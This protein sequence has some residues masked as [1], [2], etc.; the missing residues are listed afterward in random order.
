MGAIGDLQVV[1]DHHVSFLEAVDFLQKLLRV[2]DDTVADHAVLLGREYSGWNQMQCIFL[3]GD[4]DGMAGI[5]TTV[6]ADDVVVI[7]GEQINDL[8]LAFI[9]PLKTDDCCIG[10]DLHAG[11]PWAY[12][13]WKSPGPEKRGSFQPWKV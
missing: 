5:G 7:R 2:H 9:A 11:L 13:T 10:T 3:A 4:D 12:L 8:A 6:V 1:R